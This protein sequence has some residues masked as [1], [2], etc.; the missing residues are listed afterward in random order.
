MSASFIT[1]AGLAIQAFS[2][3]QSSY[4]L[5]SSIK[6]A[7]EDLKAL[8]RELQLLSTL[9]AGFREIAVCRTDGS[10]GGFVTALASCKDAL[11]SIQT[12]STD[13]ENSITK[14]KRGLRQWAAFKVSFQ[15]KKLKGYLSRLERAKSML[16]LA[17]QICM[18]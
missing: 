15:E 12:F 13:L 3:I 18:Q 1:I 16:S 6:G 4:E 5:Y 11:E 7:P 9:L 8:L 10:M 14:A 17:H 2:T